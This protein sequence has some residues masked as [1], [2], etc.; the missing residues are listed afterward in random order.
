MNYDIIEKII[1][2]E[3]QFDVIVIGGGASGTASAALLSKWGLKVILIEKRGHLGGRA[4]T[5][6]SNFG[7]MIDTGV[8]GIPY[9]DLG[10][11]KKIEKE[12]DI[13]FD[14]IDY[15]PLLA[16][17][18]AAENICVEVSDFSNNGFKEIDAIKP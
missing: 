17:Y 7:Y 6:G 18:D 14:L 4:S 11:L 13:E 15:D 10:A 8:H 5:L 12:L 1:D 9:Y 3:E 2:T 16:F